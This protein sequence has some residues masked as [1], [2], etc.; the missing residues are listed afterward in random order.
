MQLTNKIKFS[1]SNLT[2][3]GKDTF[4]GAWVSIIYKQVV[5]FWGGNYSLF[6]TWQM[7]ECV[8]WWLGW[9]L[10]KSSPEKRGLEVKS[11]PVVAFKNNLR[12][13]IDVKVSSFVVTGE[14]RMD[15]ELLKKLHP[16]RIVTIWS[17][18]QLSIFSLFVES[19]FI[20]PDSELTQWGKPYPQDICQKTC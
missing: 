12:I 7:L 4:K 10:V 16:Q 14:S 1:K 6:R 5:F 11:Y 2:G 20:W 3:D 9:V 17:I 8:S 15:L 13:I 19:V 18:W